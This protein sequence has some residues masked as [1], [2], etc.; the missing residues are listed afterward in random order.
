MEYAIQNITNGNITVNEAGVGSI[1][2]GI[3]TGIVGN[4]YPQFVAGDTY[5]VLVE[6]YANKTVTQVSDE[7]SAGCAAYIAT[8][9]PNT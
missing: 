3:T 4:N 1:P 2:C 9:Y 8:K 5:T 7:V 6:D